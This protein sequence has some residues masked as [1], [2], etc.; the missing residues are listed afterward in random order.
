MTVCLTSD[1]FSY[2]YF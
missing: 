2:I 1:D